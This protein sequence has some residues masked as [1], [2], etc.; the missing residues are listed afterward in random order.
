VINGLLSV[1]CGVYLIHMGLE[2]IGTGRFIFRGIYLDFSSWNK[3]A[4]FILVLMGLFF[5]CSSFR[6]FKA[7][8]AK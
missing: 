7:N 6:F 8:K 3:I 1:F 4:G 2:I 5:I